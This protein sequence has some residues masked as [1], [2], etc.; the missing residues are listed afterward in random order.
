[1]TKKK[2]VKTPGLM[3]DFLSWA[4]QVI[5]STDEKRYSLPLVDCKHFLSV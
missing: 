3:R 2:R 5:F 1:M 4:Q